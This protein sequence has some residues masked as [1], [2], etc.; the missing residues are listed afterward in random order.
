[1]W[2]TWCAVA[3][4]TRW[5]MSIWS[6]CFAS[7]APFGLP[8]LGFRCRLLLR[9]CCGRLHAGGMAFLATPAASTRH[10]PY[11]C[12]VLGFSL[13]SPS[14][15]EFISFSLSLPP[16][17][18]LAMLCN[19]L[20]L[21][22]H[23]C[24]LAIEPVLWGGLLA[25]SGNFWS[26]SCYLVHTLLLIWTMACS[27]VTVTCTEIRCLLWL[28]RLWPYSYWFEMILGYIYNYMFS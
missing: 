14:S 13:A 23:L 3:C 12:V 9:W 24:D 10:R 5:S 16:P 17:L 11:V 8:R 28:N 18:A 6:T 15:G 4:S 1:M 27:A 2:C 26:P 19:D 7:A 25:C 22:S 20:L 21:P